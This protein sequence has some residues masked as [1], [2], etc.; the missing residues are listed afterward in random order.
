MISALDYGLSQV[1]VLFGAPYMQTVVLGSSFVYNMQ[2]NLAIS[3]P[4]VHR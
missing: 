4:Y 3:P 1:I 2:S